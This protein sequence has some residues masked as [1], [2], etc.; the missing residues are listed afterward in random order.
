M[1][2]LLDTS[3]TADA[4]N[5][6]IIWTA[7]QPVLISQSH[8]CC[9]SHVP[10]LILVSFKS[11]PF[12]FSSS[13]PWRLC[14]GHRII[15]YL[16]DVTSK[17]SPLQMTQIQG[18]AQNWLCPSH[19]FDCVCHDVNS[20]TTHES[21]KPLTWFK[22]SFRTGVWHLLKSFQFNY[23]ISIFRR[24][25]SMLYF[26]LGGGR[27]SNLEMFPWL[28]TLSHK[29]WVWAFIFK[30]LKCIIRNCPHLVVKYIYL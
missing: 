12:S 11:A 14:L 26:F 3:S 4:I 8:T 16:R 1:A 7:R 17:I 13:V 21:L 9:L 25:Y 5:H 15:Q 10:S 29:S 2:T 19:H 20:T 30:A 22:E 6:A 23:K 24:I 18:F 28:L 27:E